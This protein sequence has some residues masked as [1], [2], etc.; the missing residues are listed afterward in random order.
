MLSLPSLFLY[1]LSSELTIV[2]FDGDYEDV[3]LRCFSFS[4]FLLLDRRRFIDFFDRLLGEG[5]PS[6]SVLLSLKGLLRFL[7][8]LLLGC[9]FRDS[10]ALGEGSLLLRAW[11]LLDLIRKGLF[12]QSLE[13]LSLSDIMFSL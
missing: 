2:E 10:L 7:G 9:S 8:L 11:S 3:Y 4:V 13:P 1:L 12:S 6:S 5:V